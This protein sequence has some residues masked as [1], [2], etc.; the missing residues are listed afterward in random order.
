MRNIGTI[1]DTLLFIA[2][3]P[4]LFIQRVRES[5]EEG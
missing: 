3:H 2:I 4:Q 5:M 1:L